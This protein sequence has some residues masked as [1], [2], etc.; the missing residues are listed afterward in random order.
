M[1]P[2]SPPPTTPPETTSVNSPLS[3]SP[4]GNSPGSCS[5]TLFLTSSGPLCSAKGT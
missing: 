2:S 4:V 1:L 5:T 3:R